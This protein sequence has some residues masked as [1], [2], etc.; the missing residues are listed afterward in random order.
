MIPSKFN[1]IKKR[2][3]EGFSNG[4]TDIARNYVKIYNN[5]VS[6]IGK[7]LD[8]AVMTRRL[9]KYEAAAEALE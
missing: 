9:A 2:Y 3:S 4:K 6:L 1:Q 7:I 5:S 8:G